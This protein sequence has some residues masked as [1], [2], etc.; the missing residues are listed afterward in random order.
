MPARINLVLEPAPPHAPVLLTTRRLRLTTLDGADADDFLRAAR[1]SRA[2]HRPWVHPPC[3]SAAFA[4]RIARSRGPQ[5]RAFVVRRRDDAALVGCVEISQIVLGPLRSAYL[6]YYVFAGHARRGY[7]REA[8]ARLLRH[9]FGEL[10]LHRLEANI[11]PGNAASIALV[12]SLGFEREGYSPRYLKI[13]GR[14]RDH[15]RWAIRADMLPL[16]ARG[17]RD[18]APD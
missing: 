11:Q 8:L 2:L 10:G 13:G 9:A 6:G 4:E 1:A 3:S 16:R 15:E 14:W 17:G 5:Q 7:M 12:R 18:Q